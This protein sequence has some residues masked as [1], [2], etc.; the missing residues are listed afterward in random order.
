MSRI[1]N[2]ISKLDPHSGKV[3]FY[4]HYMLSIISSI[5]VL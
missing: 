4:K 3:M 1:S 2:V 5:A